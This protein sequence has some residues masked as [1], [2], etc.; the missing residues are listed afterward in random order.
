MWNAVIKGC[1]ELGQEEKAIEFAVEMLSIG[2]DPDA[3]MFLEILHMRS[4]FHHCK[5]R[6]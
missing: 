5:R 1:E 4:L 2:I 3:V 6:W